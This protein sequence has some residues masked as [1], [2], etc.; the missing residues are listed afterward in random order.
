MTEEINFKRGDIKVIEISDE[1]NKGDGIAKIDK[2]VLIVPKGKMGKRYEVTITT[3][4]EKFAFAR[5]IREIPKQEV[6]EK[7]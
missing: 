4:Y 6:D 3:I 7:W 5:I 2:F 1:G